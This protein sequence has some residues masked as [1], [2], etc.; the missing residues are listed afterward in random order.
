M[1]AAEAREVCQH[2]WMKEA[3]DKFVERQ[4]RKEVISPVF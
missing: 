4:H 3:L 2:W 1:T